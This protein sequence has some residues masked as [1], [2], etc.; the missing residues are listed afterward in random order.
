MLCIYSV[1]K[2]CLA[3]NKLVKDSR[4]EESKK[5]RLRLSFQFKD[6]AFEFR[7]LVQE[8]DAVVRQRHLP[9]QEQLTP[10]MKSTSKMV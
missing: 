1:F 10:A 7:P 6:I 9:E 4:C 2:N 3:L 8:E 5:I